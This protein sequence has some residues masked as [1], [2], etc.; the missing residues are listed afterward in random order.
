MIEYPIVIM[1]QMLITIAAVVLVGCG[2]PNI[3]LIEAVN[4]GNIE[5]ARKALSIGADPNIKG[6]LES[7]V[8][9]NALIVDHQ[10]AQLLIDKGANVNNDELLHGA[11][12]SGIGL[13]GS[14]PVFLGVAVNS[15]KFLIKNG[16]DVNMKDS[17]GRSPLHCVDTA[18]VAEILINAG[19]D[20]NALNEPKTPFDPYPFRGTPLDSLG[21]HFPMLNVDPSLFEEQTT[22]NIQ[23][24][25]N[26]EYKIILN[27][28][29]KH[30]AK[31]SEELKAEGK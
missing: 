12:N 13:W 5:L 30:G 10:L 17:N 7:S 21:S 20:V 29:R 28:L 16:A 18:E 4:S 24:K 27:L 22:K 8:L 23:K 2:D 26:Q 15:T 14:N 1:K 19:A 6:E 25:Q 3:Q 9:E 31:T 11:V